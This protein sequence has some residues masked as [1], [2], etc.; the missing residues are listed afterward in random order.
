M[1][2]A[3][4]RHSCLPTNATP[5]ADMKPSTDL[6]YTDVWTDEVA[7][8]RSADASFTINYTTLPVSPFAAP[9]ASTSSACANGYDTTTAS[10]TYC[11]IVINYETHI[12]PIWEPTATRA[13]AAACTACHTAVG[14]AHLTAGQLELTSG[15]SSDEPDHIVS[16]REL[17]FNDQEQE[18]NAGTLQ[19]IMI[20]RDILVNGQ[21]IDLDMDGNP[22]Q[23]TVPDPAR[24]TRATMST[25]GARN[26]E[27]MELMTGL[28]LNKDGNQPADTQNHNTMLTPSELKLI[29]EW[30]DIGAQYFNNPFDAAVPT[31]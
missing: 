30:L 21:T 11:R 12:Q 27:F 9:A 26:S 19:D 3:R 25:A 28:D 20:T 29:S 17:L 31:N 7:A 10:F 6:I 5:C 4:A 8:N 1:A 13:G 14:F 23:E 2:E 16:Y 18:D 24:V 22:D 15:P